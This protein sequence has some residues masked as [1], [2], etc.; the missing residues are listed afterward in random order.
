[1]YLGQHIQS[2]SCVKIDDKLTEYFDCTIGTR[3]GCVASPI[4]FSLFIND[5]VIYLRENCGN[6][7]FVSQDA[8]NLLTLLFADDVA[9]F[10]DTVG[11]LQKISDCIASF[12]DSV[13]MK[14]NL[15]KTKILVFRNGGPL[16]EIEK[17]FYNGNPVEV[18]SF[19]KYLGMYFTP[20]L[21]WSKTK[22]MLSKQALKAISNIIRYQRNFGRF[23][24]KGMFKIFDTVVRPIFCYGSE[25]W[26]F[27]YSDV[28][29]KT[30]IQFCK[31]YC[32]LS[33]NVADFFALG[34]CGRLPLC[35][36]YMCNCIKYWLKIIRMQDSRYPKQC[37]FMLKRLDEVGRKT[38]ATNIRELLYMYG[39]GYAWLAHDVG[40]DDN[41]L[42]QFKQRIID[43]YL[44]KWFSDINTSPKANHYKC[45]KSL[46]DV[47]SYI[48]FD[49]PF[50]L[51][52]LLAN[53]RCSGH[54]LMTEK[55]RHNAIDAQYRFC[56]VCMETNIYVVEDEY[57]FFFECRIYDEIRNSYFKQSWIRNKSLNMFYT[58]ME[59]K[60]VE[61]I[62]KIANYLKH[63][64]ALRNTV[65]NN[66]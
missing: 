37:Y 9:G 10:S 8:D 43:S 51:R 1:M 4:I 50:E 40:N 57:H 33:T 42:C 35:T 11:R 16:K 12:C 24:S 39:F 66:A 19:Y 56:P 25:I 46:L 48:S 44:Q 21:V 63:A 59:S 20:K 45:F 65:L 13:G 54:S 47:E 27:K 60:N 18:V 14:I 55:G 2:L 6:G 32:G 61:N 58:I 17:W 28:I 30:H 41:F 29:E 53:F 49:I 3:Q 62:L 5:L 36:T 31:R 7:I 15:D 26:G 23:E 34:E 38:W 64:F 22:D 52:K